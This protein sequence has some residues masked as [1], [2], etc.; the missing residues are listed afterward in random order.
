[1]Q[2]FIHKLIF[3]IT[4]ISSFACNLQANEE[5]TVRS[6][7]SSSQSADQDVHKAIDNDL[8][9][10]WEAEKTAF[11]QWIEIE[12]DTIYYLTKVQQI[13]NHSS[14]W[15]FIIEGSRD[16]QFW[17]PLVDN[18]KGTAGISFAESIYGYYQHIRL[19]VLGSSDNYPASSKKFSIAGIVSGGINILQYQG[20]IEAKGA[21]Y[22]EA[23]KAADNDISTYWCATNG[24]YP[25]ILKIDLESSFYITNIQQV[26]K[27]YDNWKYRIEASNDNIQWTVVTN[28]SSGE[29]GCEFNISV[30]N[31]YRYLR[32]I[33][34]GSTTGYWA[35]SCEFRVFAY[36][37]NNELMFEKIDKRNLAL[38]VNVS[39]S[40]IQSKEFSQ[41]KAVDADTTSAWY[42]DET[43]AFPQWLMVDLKNP[44]Q[45]KQIE[46]IFADNDNWKF[47][48][49][50]SLDKQDW[51]LL[52]DASAGLEGTSFSQP[53]NG[54][55]R[56]IRI[57][58]LGSNNHRAS[59]KNLKITGF[60]MPVS[61]RWWQNES[62][63]S[64]YYTK[65][66]NYVLQDITADLDK[67]KNQGYNV[68]ELMC[69][70]KGKADIWGGLGATDNYDIDSSIGTMEDFDELIR[71]AHERDMKILFF[72]NV[73]YC[74]DEAPFF[75]KAC[76]DEKNNTHSKERNWFHF[77]KTK[78]DDRWFWSEKAQAYYYSYW[79]N[80]DG[81]AGRIPS[82][83]FNNQEWR[84]ET[85]K[86]L[87]FWA[88]KGLDGV[89]LDAPEAYDGIND[90]IIENYITNTL[91]GYD[92]LTNAE[93][94]GDINRWFE[95]F[96][97]NCIQGFDMYGW[98]GGG[99]SEVLNALRKN[100]PFALNDMLKGYRDKAVH[101]NGVTLTP[102][103]WEMQATENERIF[104][105]AYLISIGT[106]FANHC[107]DYHYVAQDIIPTWNTES[108]NR[109]YALLKTQS[110]YKGLA[111]SGQRTKLP[112]NNDNKYSA[113]KRTNKDGNVSALVIFNFQP[114]RQS[115]TVNLHNSGIKIPQMPINLLT[116]TATD[117]IQND[118]Y[119]VSLPAYGFLFLGVE[120]DYGQKTTGVN[121]EK[122]ES[123]LRVEV[124]PNPFVNDL[125]V[126]CPH[127]L[128]NIKIYSV[129]GILAREYSVRNAD[130]FEINNINLS[131]GVYI[132]KITDINNKEYTVKIVRN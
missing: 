12:L 16:G 3:S 105:T 73:G 124:F 48:I 82:Y 131:S 26:F 79:G 28:K 97:Y 86:Y 70:Y 33:I 99:R 25:Q 77:S 40:S 121:I 27:D 128:K 56:Y 109:F 126:K 76:E 9:T 58:V 8:S 41:H 125:T 116:G 114:L 101:M 6:V 10:Y 37:G 100:N 108:Q 46:Q 15:K 111:P 113:F 106:L 102:P 1:M 32:L 84:D 62:G 60:G 71:Q 35:N 14:V 44:C 129:S 39:S 20:K 130:N 80:T 55:Y 98:G 67:L 69:P 53:V 89:L 47:Q 17:A 18:R 103:M 94:S 95:R 54:F 43:G 119:T 74:R 34:L 36:S 90:E 85:K 75:Q 7:R 78:W 92:F 59:S 93:G 65:I 123:N 23:N 104:E 13:F 120:N 4:V 29:N 127:N 22:C 91:N 132:L 118:N 110:S 21:E 30:K 72:G 83:N 115:V 19:T 52:S 63:L 112:S 68:L 122:T 31:T 45:I 64:R 107:G 42:A 50:G 49:H 61:T 24:S 2:S 87:R 96:G 5:I 57:T 51:N 81:A 66:Y 11:P 88:N 38:N 117:P